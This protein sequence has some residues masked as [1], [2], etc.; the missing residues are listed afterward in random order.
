MN[1]LR[2]RL[3]ATLLT[4]DPLVDPLVL[5]GFEMGFGYIKAIIRLAIQG[6]GKP[7]AFVPVLLQNVRPFTGFKANTVRAGKPC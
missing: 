7:K 5:F 2:N 4:E 3:F 1:G 6:P